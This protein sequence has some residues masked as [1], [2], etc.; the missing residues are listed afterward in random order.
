[1]FLQIKKFLDY[2]SCLR[3]GKSVSSSPA[4]RNFCTLFKSR[5]KRNSGIIQSGDKSLQKSFLVGHGQVI[6]EQFRSSSR[7]ILTLETGWIVFYNKRMPSYVTILLITAVLLVGLVIV[8]V[9]LLR[10]SKVNRDNVLQL[11]QQQMADSLTQQNIRLGQVGEQLSGALQNLTTNLNDRL[12]Q[13]QQLTQQMQKSTV[14]RLESA[15]KTIADLK[16][17][18][19]QLS[20]ATQTVIQVGS[21]VKKLQDILQRPGM[22]GSLGEW[23]LESLL[24]DVLPR[25]NY[26]IKHRFK[27]GREVDVLVHLAQGHVA[28]DAK[29]PLPNFQQILEEKDASARQKLRRAFLRDVCARIDEIAQKYI[30]PDEGTLDFALMYIPAENVYYE[31]IIKLDDKEPDIGKYGR[32]RRV[33]PVSPNTLYSYLM[34]IA[35]GLKGLQIEKN[36]QIIQQKLSR[37]TGDMQLFINDFALIGRHLNNAKTKYDDSGKKLDAFQTRLQQMETQATQQEENKILNS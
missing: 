4:S 23:S 29:F 13:N 18:L 32:E 25:Q 11:L 24:G 2:F 21:E 1:M 6:N 37:F 10:G 5:V 27:N 22:R 33:I 12:S 20:Q 9:M 30:L 14:E 19:G 17:Q 31:T 26:T 35:A 15:G 28:I 7:N 34:V 16:G 36:A 3:S 8:V